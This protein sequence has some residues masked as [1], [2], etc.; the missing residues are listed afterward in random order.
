[1]RI[2]AFR[3]GRSAV[4]SALAQWFMII[5]SAASIV[6]IIISS[7]SLYPEHRLFRIMAAP[8]AIASALTILYAL[9]RSRSRLFLPRALWIAAPVALMVIHAA[10]VAVQFIRSS[11][12]HPWSQTP[13]AIM[14]VL[15]IVLLPFEAA[16]SFKADRNRMKAEQN[17]QASARALETIVVHSNMERVQRAQDENQL[18]P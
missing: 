1:M 7:I 12:P 11:D 17:A 15:V 9:T 5:L 2:Y 13:I 3:P 6:L 8:Q 10:L 18:P 16:H 4:E 14:T